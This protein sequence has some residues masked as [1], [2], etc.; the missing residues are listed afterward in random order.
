MKSLRGVPVEETGILDYDRNVFFGRSGKFLFE[1]R[2]PRKG[3]STKH[4]KAWKNVSQDT[5]KQYRRLTEDPIIYDSKWRCRQPLYKG[6]IPGFIPLIMVVDDKIVGFADMMFKYGTEYK[7]HNLVDDEVGC[8]MNLCVLDKY[9]GM[10]Y[11]SFYSHISVLIAKHFKA[12]YALGYTRFKKGMY[13]IRQKQG[14]ELVSRQGEY[15]IIR[16]KL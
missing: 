1:A 5:Q 3:D 15:A 2:Q 10:G 9:Q 13:H 8:S 6:A 11:G 7:F 4:R 14:W 12:D 16:K